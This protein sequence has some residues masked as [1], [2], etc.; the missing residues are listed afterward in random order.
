M[1][2][3]FTIQPEKALFDYLRENESEQSHK[4]T[5]RAWRSVA[6]MACGICCHSSLV[7]I[8]VEEVRAL[9]S[10]CAGDVSFDTF[11]K[12]F[13]QEGN[14]TLD[15]LTIETGRHGGCCL[16]LEK[17]PGHFSCTV[18]DDRPDVCRDFFCWPM[19]NF[20][21]YMKG[22][23]QD[24]FDAP[25]GFINNFDILLGNIRDEAFGSLFGNDAQNYMNSR[26]NSPRQSAF[27]SSQK[28]E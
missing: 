28:H 21:K 23:E 7:P 14:E 27:E 3:E 13:T 11:I 8:S 2:P 16:F 1:K 19:V 17:L 20:D 5:E 10:Q 24:M 9:H 25:A 26:K 22:G 18:W 6:C 12:N 4:I 15:N